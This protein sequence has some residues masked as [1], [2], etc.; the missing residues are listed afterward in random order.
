MAIEFVYGVSLEFFFFALFQIIANILLILAG[1]RNRGKLRLSYML[2]AAGIL[3]IVHVITLFFMPYLTLK[4]SSLSTQQTYELQAYYINMGLWRYLVPILTYG[5]FLLII[6]FYNRDHS[7]LILMASAIGFITYGIVMIR[8]NYAIFEFLNA[9]L[10]LF[11]VFLYFYM[12][13]FIG[14]LAAMLLVLYGFLTKEFNILT[15]GIVVL[16]SAILVIMLPSS[17]IVY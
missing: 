14:I 9:G 6:G 16:I 3:N 17:V 13:M 5:V 4:G 10:P 7:G 15:S 12:G 11:T 1:L 8:T 2:V